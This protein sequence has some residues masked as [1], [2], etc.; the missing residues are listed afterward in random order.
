MME[1]FGVRSEGGTHSAT[2]NG[3]IASVK[4]FI[5]SSPKWKSRV[6]QNAS[7]GTWKVLTEHLA[8][9]Q[10]HHGLLRVGA[11]LHPA[12]VTGAESAQQMVTK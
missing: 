10:A 2:R 11:L 5:A 12:G 4:A 9:K 6:H 3:P 8:W 1:Y 7:T